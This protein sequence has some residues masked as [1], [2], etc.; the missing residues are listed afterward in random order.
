[1]D[2]LAAHVMVD[3]DKIKAL[4]DDLEAAADRKTYRAKDFFVPYEKQIEFCD[5]GISK[6]ERLLS[7]GN[8][9][10]KSEIGSFEVACH[11]TGEYPDWWLGRRWDR[12]VKCWVSGVSGENVRDI[13]QKK[14]CG[15]PGVESAFGTGMIPRENFIGKPTTMRGVTDLFDTAA[16]RHKSGGISVMKFKTYEQGREKWQGETLDFVWYDE[17]PPQDIYDEGITRLAEGGMAF[18]TFTPLKGSTKV[19]N[20]FFDTPSRD[21]G[22]VIMTID[23]VTHFSPEEKQRRIDA[24]PE[25]LKRSRLRGLPAQGEGAV[26]MIPLESI[27]EDAIPFALIPKQWTWLWGIDLGIAHPFAAVLTVWDRDTDIIH[28]VHAFKQE[29]LKIYEQARIMKPFGRIRVAWPHDAHERDRGDLTPFA[30]MYKKEGLWMMDGHAKFED[31]S[32]STEAGISEM[33]ERFNTGRLKVAKH[34][35]EWHKEFERYHRK[36][37][38]LVKKD[39]DIMSATR[40]AVMAKRAGQPHQ[41]ELRALRGTGQLM[42]RDIDFD[43]S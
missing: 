34:L 33:N 25:H 35:I 3:A 14:L 42:A 31:G 7:A 12:P 16:I 11:L 6:R 2:R 24:C 13:V 10:G 36:D 22:L 21:Q 41:P 29:N 1:M 19:V 43:L 20:K 28:V 40:I 17:E 32:N 30:S 26:F 23:D 18:L 27:V 38:L 8:Q 5:M 4:L 39:D 37:G 9:T 15:Q